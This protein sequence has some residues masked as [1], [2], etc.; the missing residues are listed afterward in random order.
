MHAKRA[1]VFYWKHSSVRV[2]PNSASE[3]C[4]ELS[5]ALSIDTRHMYSTLSI[6]RKVY[7]HAMILLSRIRYGLIEIAVCFL[8]HCVNC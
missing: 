7:K 5:Y 6:S 8:L 4:L 3:L 2:L 1:Y